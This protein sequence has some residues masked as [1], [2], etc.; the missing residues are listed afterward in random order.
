MALPLKGGQRWYREPDLSAGTRL[1]AN[2]KKQT[3]FCT[4][5]AG[6]NGEGVAFVLEAGQRFKSPSRPGR[7][8]CAA[9][10]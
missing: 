10:P 6:D 4:V 9:S 7:T 2:Y 8:S 3:Y 5:E 1:V